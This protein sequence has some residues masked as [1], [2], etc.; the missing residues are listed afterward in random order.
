MLGKSKVDRKRFVIFMLLT[1]S[2]QHQRKAGI[3]GEFQEKHREYSSDSDL[4]AWARKAEKKLQSKKS[5]TTVIC[6]GN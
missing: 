2:K 4:G 6:F 5:H 1:Q 3:L